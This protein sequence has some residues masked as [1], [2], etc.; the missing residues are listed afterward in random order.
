MVIQNGRDQTNRDLGHKS[1]SFTVKNY[2]LP[3]GDEERVNE[4]QRE[5]D[6][7]NLI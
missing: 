5:D 6:C 4:R 3:T 2:N 7:L 1:R